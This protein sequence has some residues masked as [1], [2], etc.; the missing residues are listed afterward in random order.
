MPVND[1][2]DTQLE[3]TLDAQAGDDTVQGNAAQDD[4]ISAGAGDDTVSTGAADTVAAGAGDDTVAPDNDDV[5]AAFDEP[6]TGKT[7]T[8]AGAGGAGGAGKGATST[9]ATDQA[10]GNTRNDNAAAQ[11]ADDDFGDI[12]KDL[13][14]V[15]ETL[16]TEGKLT[17]PLKKLLDQ[18]KNLLKTVK[19]LEE[20]QK[21]QTNERAW[22]QFEE[23][24]GI[25][26]S[27]PEVRKLLSRNALQTRFTKHYQQALQ[28]GCSPDEAR[29]EA[30][31]TLKAEVK[32]VQKQHGAKK[33]APRVATNA[34][35]SRLSP[36]GGASNRQTKPK[37]SAEDAFDN[38]DWSLPKA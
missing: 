19:Q 32:Q 21:V 33:P 2:L 30:R 20:Q 14:E 23:Q 17:K 4:T 36:P 8:A 12:E 6:Q 37:L 5:F 35:G 16:G 27:A 15:E 13:A 34:N 24:L 10:A 38:G 29:G 28:S 25:P 26:E 7:G 1:T 3:D 22:Q 18:N 31:A 9:V 11:T